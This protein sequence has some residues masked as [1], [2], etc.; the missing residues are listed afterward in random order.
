MHN[1]ANLYREIFLK[2]KKQIDKKLVFINNKEK[3]LFL[4]TTLKDEILKS[5]N[6]I[7]TEFNIAKCKN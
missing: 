6:E 1:K 2:S 7:K 3:R 4:E 5:E